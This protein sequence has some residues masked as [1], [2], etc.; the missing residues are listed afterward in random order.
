MIDPDAI[1]GD[2]KEDDFCTAWHCEV[3]RRDG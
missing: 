3:D 1:D 2:V